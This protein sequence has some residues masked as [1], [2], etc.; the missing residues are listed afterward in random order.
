LNKPKVV[1]TRRIPET[2]LNM[3]KEKADIFI[4]DH[5]ETPIPR[6]VLLQE[7]K[8][9]AGIYTNV[10]DPI[11]KELMENSPLLKVVSTMAVGFDNI[12]IKEA[13][14]RGI[15]VGHTPGVLTETT[16]DLTFALLM[17]TARRL[18]EAHQ[19]V[20]DGKWQSWSPMLMTGQDIHHATIGIIGMGRIGEGV[21]RR[22]A[23]FDMNIL[24]H[25]RRPLPE[26]EAR[27]GASYRSLDD[28]LKE[29]DYVVMLA[30]STPDTYRMMGEREFGLMK[31]SAI[32][33]NA[34]RGTNVDE[35]ALFQALKENKIYAAGLD[36]FEKEPITPDHPLLTLPNVVA[37]PH[38]GSATIANRINMAKLAAQNLVLG[39]EGK[40]PVHCVNGDQFGK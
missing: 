7:S 28:L 14:K 2:A 12:D 18:V 25:N 40:T 19:Y 33:I 1:I 11:D 23:G 34:A 37:A 9:A 16:A 39:L 4:W 21:A 35:K 38:I 31:S 24:Y 17:A 27:L 22:A 8:D 15:A 30:P 20:L 13:T 3:I 10:G 29:S 32:F 36:V 5:E 26:T 6:D